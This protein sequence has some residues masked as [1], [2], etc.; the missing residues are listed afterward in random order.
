MTGAAVRF[1]ASKRP[2]AWEGVHRARYQ[3]A[4]LYARSRRVLDVACGS[5]YGLAI[6]ESEGGTVI[7]VDLDRGALQDA[8]QSFSH[9]LVAADGSRLPF[10]DGAFDLVT[11]FETLE[12]LEQRGR[13]LREIRRVLA[14]SGLL[15]LSTPNANVT[16]P[17]EGRPRNP[18]H[19]HEYRPD[20]L[21]AEILSVFDRVE[22]LGQT[23]HPRF[24]LSPFRE[25]QQKLPKTLSVQAQLL[26]W[27]ILY[28]LPAAPRDAASQ[29]LWGHPLIAGAGDYRFLPDAVDSA[30]VL[31][32]ICK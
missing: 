15:I 30:P 8:R 29:L 19:L 11:S 28:R 10:A 12:H 5:G 32:A 31:V 1:T 17:I 21:R 27:K 26:A 3:F 6:L 22:M 7:G 2:D 23:L 25:D 9:P 4:R 14:S 18:H 24:R 20:E 13:F 16:A